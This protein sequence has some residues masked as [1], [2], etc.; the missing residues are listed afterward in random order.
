MLRI[1]GLGGPVNVCIPCMVVLM[2]I[3]RHP[4]NWH[5]PVGIDA[6][7]ALSLAPPH[8]LVTETSSLSLRSEAFTIAMSEEPYRTDPIMLESRF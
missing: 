3:A 1:C 8:P 4:E 2:R 6:A 7:E 5:M